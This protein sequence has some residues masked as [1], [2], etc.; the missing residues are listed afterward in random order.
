MVPL[1]TSC[2]VCVLDVNSESTESA[3]SSSAPMGMDHNY[4]RMET[5]C[6]ECRRK[7]DT[8]NVMADKIDDLHESVI[9]KN[10]PI[11]SSISNNSFL[12][13]SPFIASDK[14][15]K[16]NTGLPNRQALNRLFALL[17]NKAGRMRYWTG[18]KRYKPSGFNRIFNTTPVKS[19]RARSL[20][21]LDELVL[22]LMK[23]R[24]AVTNEFLASMFSI[25]YGTCSS[26]ICT[27]IKFLAKQLKCLVFWPSKEQIRTLMPA[28]LR[29]L[30]PNLRCTI[31]CSE[32][33]IQRPRD[34]KLQAA[35][36][37]DY[38]HHNT[39]KY[40]VCITPDGLISYI[41]KAWG[42]RTTDRYIVQ[43]SGFLDLIEPYDTIMAD[44]GFTIREDLLFRYAN[45][46]IPPPSTGLTQMPRQAV[47]K[48]KKLVMH[49]FM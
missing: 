11:C 30:Y 34:L 25:S 14:K 33:F 37:S 28:S 2:F 45:L 39:L 21:C 13:C 6:T 23:L 32:T 8:I 36:W 1:S 48:T 24:L 17:K 35:T 38:K 12:K 18:K 15:V 26:I 42:G 3:I 5:D 19:G 49:V 9:V 10:S 22:T 31:D 44:R 4:S 47:L 29:K 7:Q 41:S 40:L 43:N 20:H 27:W 46:E 16:L